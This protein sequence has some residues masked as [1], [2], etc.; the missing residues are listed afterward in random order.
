[1]PLLSGSM[2]TSH[3]SELQNRRATVLPHVILRTIKTHMYA[4]KR[5]PGNRKRP[6]SASHSSSPSEHSTLGAVAKSTVAD[7]L[8]THMYCVL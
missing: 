1:M 2:S 4:K 6:V 7:V 5:V 3:F 8:C